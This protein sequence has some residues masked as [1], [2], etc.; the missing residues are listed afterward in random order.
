MKKNI[1]KEIPTNSRNKKYELKSKLTSLAD[2]AKTRINNNKI[3]R[4][5]ILNLKN[6]ISQ[7]KKKFLKYSTIK[8]ISKNTKEL[9]D[10]IQ[11][12]LNQTISNHKTENISLH[13]AINALKIKNETIISKGRENIENILNNYDSIQEKNFIIKNALQSKESDINE[14]SNNI[15]KI[16]ADSNK[17]EVDIAVYYES[18]LEDELDFKDE[19]QK[20]MQF[21][22]LL[23]EQKLMQINRYINKCKKNTKKIPQLKLSRK[24]IKKYIRTL[25]NL[26][27]NFDCITFP[28]NR[29]IIIEGEECLQESNEI[30]EVNIINNNGMSFSEESESFLNETD[31]NIDIREIELIRNNYLEDQSKLITF[32]PIPKLDFALINFNKQKLNYDYDEK[33]LSRNDME[34][35]DMIS[36]RIIKLK[37]DIK[38]LNE[39]NIKL[40]DKIKKYEKNICKLNKIFI[41]MNYQNPNSIRIK[42]VKKRKFIFDSAKAFSI[43]SKNT[44]SLSHRYDAISYKNKFNLNEGI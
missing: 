39:K 12:E 13:S 3:L 27:A 35:H 21:H 24:N 11:K 37:D 38:F 14:L 34:E 43:P 4:E 42:S 25:T 40:F 6:Q 22:T 2:N 44:K 16:K 5:R 19:F 1:Y 7:H 41:N 10:A 32:N 36:L 17:T 18:E 8:L 23:T 26:I 29:N 15:S 9:S 28:E 31:I 20:T 30:E 33:S